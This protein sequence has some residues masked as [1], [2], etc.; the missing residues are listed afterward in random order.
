MEG[1]RGSKVQGNLVND[2]PDIERPLL[3]GSQGSWARAHA[4]VHHLLP[5]V[6]DFGLKTSIFYETHRKIVADSQGCTRPPSH[7]GERGGRL[8]MQLKLEMHQ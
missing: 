7:P 6:M 2:K 5:Q 4:V 1:I 8:T 3:I